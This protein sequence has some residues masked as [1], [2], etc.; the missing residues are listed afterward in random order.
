MNGYGWIKSHYAGDIN[1]QTCFTG[2]AE[3]AYFVGG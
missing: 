1:K 2:F 3:T